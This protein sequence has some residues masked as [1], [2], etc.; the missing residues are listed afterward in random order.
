MLEALIKKFPQ[1]NERIMELV[2]MIGLQAS[3]KTTFARSRFGETY[4]YVSKDLLKNNGR[5][6]R[7]Q[8]QLIEEAL[9]QGLSVVVDNTNPTSEWFHSLR[10]LPGAWILLWL[11][12][13]GFTKFTEREGFEKLFDLR[14][15]SAL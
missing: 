10:C 14:F 9:Q 4:R 2:I 8:R 15:Q 3:G 12:G 6:A 11:D 1:G 5:P 13:R 7:R